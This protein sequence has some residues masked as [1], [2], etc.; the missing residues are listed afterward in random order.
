MTGGLA[1]DANLVFTTDYQSD[2]LNL[3]VVD[4]TPAFD[5]GSISLAN[6]T[7]GI[8]ILGADGQSYEIYATTDFVTWTKLSTDVTSAGQIL[9]MD[10]DAGNFPSRFYRA[11]L[12]FP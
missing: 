12:V 5:P 8:T 3:T 2:A 4:G 6:G 1:S 7:F 11:Q 10:A 9:F